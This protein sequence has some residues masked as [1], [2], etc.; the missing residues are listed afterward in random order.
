VAASAA[1]P[2]LALHQLP[3]GTGRPT[4]YGQR[5]NDYPIAHDPAYLDGMVVDG[6]VASA[7]C[8]YGAQLY[9]TAG[10]GI[11]AG[12]ASVYLAGGAYAFFGSSTIAYGAADSNG[13]ADLLSQFFLQR[14]LAGASVG[15]ATLEARLRF[16]RDTNVLD[17]SDL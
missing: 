13:Q 1:R 17:P 7:E 11:H 14:V 16:V 8:C 6:T 10:A 3:R 5:G 15:R 4:L 9:D 2:A 12:I